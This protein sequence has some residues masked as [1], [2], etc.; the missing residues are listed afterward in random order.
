MYPS[1][2][3]SLATITWKAPGKGYEMKKKNFFLINKW[4]TK[5]MHML[6]T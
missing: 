5:Q 3:T 1:E 6:L 2:V 4:V